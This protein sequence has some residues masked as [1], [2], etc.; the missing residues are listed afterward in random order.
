MKL[1][2]LAFAAHPDDVEISC[3]GTLV[4][5]IQQGKKVGVID[6]T[7]GELG[8]RGTPE[9]RVKEAATSAT[10]MGLSA[11]ENLGFRDGFF[12][13]DEE[14]Q[15]AVIKIIRKYQ[16]NIVLANAI[17]DRHSDHGKAAILSKA[18]CFLAGLA[19][20][21]IEQA[22]VKQQ[23]W[24]PKAV[25]HYIQSIPHT[26][27]FIV[28]VT[29]AWKTK[30]KAIAAF[31]SQFHDPDST[32]PE[33][34]VSSPRFLRMIEARGIHYGHEIGVHYG[35]GFTIERTIGVASIEDLI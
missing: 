11:R 22:G 4:K 26:P 33:T 3:A 27:D 25:Y 32:E 10:I 28:D 16:P 29:S 15:L 12:K 31:K 23:T 5:A 20:I 19:K 8:T 1:D 2:I 21:K 17:D 30:M 34:Y 14:H 7:K 24:R 6:F 18:A 9:I 35:E 13:N